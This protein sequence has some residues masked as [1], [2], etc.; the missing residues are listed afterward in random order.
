V[1]GV[2]HRRA[3]LTDLTMA[4]F[5]SHEEAQEWVDWK[6]GLPKIN[7]YA[8]ADEASTPPGLVEVAIEPRSDTER[9]P[10]RLALETLVSED[11]AFEVSTDPESGQLILRGF[12]ELHLHGKVE[13]LRWRYNIDARVGAPQVAFRERITRPAEAEY[14]YAKQSGSRGEFAAVKL[15]VEGNEPGSRNQFESMLTGGGLPDEYIRSVEKAIRSSFSSGVVAAFPVVNVRVTLIDGAFHDADSSVRSFEIAGREA[16]RAALQ[17]AG[18]ELLEPIM[19][20]EVVSPGEYTS[21]IVRD[22]NLRRGQMLDQ[23]SRGNVAVIH[24]TAPLINM[25]GYANSLREVSQGRASFS[26]RFDHYAPAPPNG[27]VPPV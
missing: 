18:P 3:D 1:A 15:R 14:T 26:M 21:A 9:K 13:I 23:R 24:A 12:S 17:K 4:D 20:V 19:S 6:S 22:L 27:D 5:V 11:P 2:I 10:L 25:F 7:P 16:F 8:V